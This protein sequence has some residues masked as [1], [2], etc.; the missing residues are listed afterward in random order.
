[1]E[2]GQV[3]KC[4][5]CEALI[6]VLSKGKGEGSLSCCGKTMINVTPSEAKQIT[7]EY[8]MTAPGAP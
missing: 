4:G 3:Y 8:G 1:M 7:K 2:K 5:Q 6:A